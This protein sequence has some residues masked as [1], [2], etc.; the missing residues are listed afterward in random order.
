MPSGEKY[1]D[2]SFC[3]KVELMFNM[4]IPAASEE[5]WTWDLSKIY[6]LMGLGRGG[7]ILQQ[8]LIGVSLVF[9]V[10]HVVQ[11]I[12]WSHFFNKKESKSTTGTPS[13]PPPPSLQPTFSLPVSLEM[14]WDCKEKLILHHFKSGSERAE[15]IITPLD[16]PKCLYQDH[17]LW[18]TSLMER[19]VKI[20]FFIQSA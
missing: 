10:C 4:L 9:K 16:G 8:C 15:R 7:R 12:G 18:L 3:C 20:F 17:C 6:W 11:W 13:S 19:H 1:E 14:Y 2:N 5:K